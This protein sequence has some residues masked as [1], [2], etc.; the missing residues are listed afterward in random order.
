MNR[1]PAALISDSRSRRSRFCNAV[2]AVVAVLAAG[3]CLGVTWPGQLAGTRADGLEGRLAGK[4]DEADGKAIKG[5]IAKYAK[6]IDDADTALAA[7]IWSSSPQVSF[8]HPR[9]HERGWKAVKEN[10][11]E[12]LMGKTFSER[13]LTAKNIEVQ[14]YGDTAV[15][16]FYWDFAAKMRGG[17]PVLKTQGRE[18][19]VYHKDEHGWALVHVHYSGMPVT[20]K[21]EGF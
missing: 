21:R 6:S 3:A 5:L 2:H 1:F 15:A 4:A 8:I 11:Y 16:T 18:T 17:G 19:Q 7:T 12:N 9:G 10:V 13:K 20:G 14:V